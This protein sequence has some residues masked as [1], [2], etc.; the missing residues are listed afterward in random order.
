MKALPVAA[1]A[2]LAALLGACSTLP[3][4]P[5]V[6][7]MPAPNKPF[8]VFQHDDLVCR[9][10]ASRSLGVNPATQEQNQVASGAVAGAAV[11]AV[12]GAVLSGGDGEDIAQGAGAGMIAG[13]AM[14]ADR[15]RHD[16]YQ[17]QQ[18]YDIAYMQCMYSKGN[19]VPG[20]PMARSLPPPRR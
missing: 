11:G 17:L 18:R 8:E 10:Y 2:V 7:V 9:D 20:Y 6:A 15:A 4:G 5:S 13:T 16:S 12:A 1:T 14:G 19:Q 3:S